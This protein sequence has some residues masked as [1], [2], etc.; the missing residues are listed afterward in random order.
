MKSL[1]FI[2]ILVFLGLTTLSLG[3]ES[4]SESKVYD[5]NEEDFDTQIQ[6]SDK[7]FFVMF[8]APWCPHCKQL[9]PV[10]DEASIEKA[11]VANWGK[12]DCTKNEKLCM[13]YQVQG[14]PSLK[15]FNNGAVF[16]Y[17][18]ERSADGFVD[19]ITRMNR[20][21][22]TQV[23]SQ[24]EFDK[25]TKDKPSFVAFFGEKPERD[26][27]EAAAKHYQANVD[28]VSTEDVSLGKPY[29]VN[30][31][32]ALVAV[33]SDSVIP[34]EGKFEEESLR[35][36]IGR[37][38]FGMVPELGP[39]NF[40]D[41]TSLGL[42]LV[43]VALDPNADYYQSHMDAARETAEKHM[44]SYVFAWLDGVRWV[45][46]LEGAFK[47]SGDQVPVTVILDPIKEMY[48]Q[49]HPATTDDFE[50]LFQGINSGEIEGISLRQ[51]QGQEPEGVAKYQAMAEEYLHQYIWY[52]VGGSFVLGFIV[53]KILSFGGKA[54]AQKKTKKE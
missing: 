26:I 9:I 8:F 33:S 3:H 40:Q 24:E 10:W 37:A 12:V 53:A 39:H 32:P 5:L 41:L 45:Q 44:N 23:S 52:S 21:P 51:G 36:F 13:K 46:Y 1:S 31:S 16:D 15:L 54:P 38:R 6:N 25:F 50:E 30:K 18:G 49:S 19:F 27:V 14:Y 48:Y 20:P 42:P 7:P 22:L 28:F 2:L 47:I 11:E 35:K 43:I 17:S 4:S 34:F 29:K